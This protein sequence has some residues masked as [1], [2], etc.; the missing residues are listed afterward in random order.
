LHVDEI[1]ESF[2]SGEAVKACALFDEITHVSHYR[3]KDGVEV[4]FV[5]ESLSGLAV[6]IEVRAGATV[7]PKDFRGLK[8]VGESLAGRLACGIV[9]HDGER[10]QQFDSKL[11]AM[12]FRMLWEA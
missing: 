3:D 2:V 8:R 11:F 9:L 12:P 10:I 5:I 1:I 4:D 7:H 6:G